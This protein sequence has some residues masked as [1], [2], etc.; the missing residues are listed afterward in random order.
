MLTGCGTG[1]RLIF[2][3]QTA[4]GLDISGIN[5]T[6]P[7]VAL[8]YSRHE[9]AFVPRKQDGSSHSVYGGL[10]ADIRFKIPPEYIIKQVF[11]TGDAA[12]NAANNGVG[13]SDGGPPATVITNAVNI[14]P[15]PYTGRLTDRID[16]F[17]PIG[18]PP[19]STLAFFTGTKFGLHVSY[20]R[21]ELSPNALIGYRRT[22]ATL[23]PVPDPSQE[24][25]PVYADLEI[26]S[27]QHESTNKTESP[28]PSRLGGV[29]IRQSFATGQAALIVSSKPSVQQKLRD[30]ASVPIE[31]VD[32]LIDLLDSLSVASILSLAQNPPVADAAADAA[33][34]EMDP[35]D[36]YKQNARA[37][38]DSLRIRIRIA[39]KDEDMILKWENAIRGKIANDSG[40]FNRSFR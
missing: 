26:N 15:K 21:E 5:G 2:T 25:R 1:S 33:V 32:R 35:S 37:A 13:K 11:A 16:S 12:T 40:S 3:T 6:S 30:A 29:R 10:D 36:Y 14:G 7:K 39:Q 27:T 17:S 19:P 8:A 22:E 9:L 31:R 34:K 18:R 28:K 20:G 24:V 4:A 23:I 38:W